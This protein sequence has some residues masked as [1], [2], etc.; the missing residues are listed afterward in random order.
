M[1]DQDKEVYLDWL[2]NKFENSI[3]SRRSHIRQKQIAE[4]LKECDIS[5][6]Y[7]ERNNFIENRLEDGYRY[8]NN[9][10]DADSKIS[11]I[12]NLRKNLELKK[13]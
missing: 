9:L 4:I 11:D 10:N 6:P 1:L 2:I 3:M 5:K 7:E 13:K 8:F 12:D